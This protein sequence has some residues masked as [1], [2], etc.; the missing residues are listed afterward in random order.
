MDEDAQAERYS[1]SVVLS[2]PDELQLPSNSKRNVSFWRRE[3]GASHIKQGSG[4]QV[5]E[6]IVLV[7]VNPN[8]IVL[9]F[10]HLVNG[11]I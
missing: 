8:L 9:S 4:F 7:S 10:V 2:R 11:G 3:T 6:P 1:H 5:I